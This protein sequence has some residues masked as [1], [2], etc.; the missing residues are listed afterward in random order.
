[1]ENNAVPKGREIPD[2]LSVETGSPFYDRKTANLI[3][4][5]F[6]G[7]RQMNVM[8]YCLSEQWIRRQLVTGLGKP[9]LERG[10]PI[11]MKF[12]GKLEVT[13]KV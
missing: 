13:W 3:N 8:E 6:N 9:K 10:K 5:T 7:L 1:M 2:R 12:Q 11:V 4:V